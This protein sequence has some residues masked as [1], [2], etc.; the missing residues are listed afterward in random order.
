MAKRLVNESK[1]PPTPRVTQSGYEQR[2]MRPPTPRVSQST[3]A[4]RPGTNADRTA[5]NSE[6]HGDKSNKK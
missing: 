5:A 3:S 4:T 2:S 6:N 1:K